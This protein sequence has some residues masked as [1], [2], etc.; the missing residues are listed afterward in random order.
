MPA[1]PINNVAQVF[2]DPQVVARGMVREL[3][4]VGGRGVRII[5][6]P[7]RLSRT[8]PAY[9]RPPPTLAQ[10]NEEVFRDL[11]GLT[12]QECADLAKEGAI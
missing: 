9:S 8:P 4:Q 10:H 5:A 6:S 12:E 1:S 2:A 11:L 7:I 3:G